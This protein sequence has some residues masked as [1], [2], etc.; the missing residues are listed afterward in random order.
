L[1]R[2]EQGCLVQG[3]DQVEPRLLRLPFGQIGHP[4]RM[5]WD[6]FG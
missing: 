2:M 1:Q 6:G 4:E 5:V 3:F